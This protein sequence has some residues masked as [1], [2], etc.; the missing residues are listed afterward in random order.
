MGPG[1]TSGTRFALLPFL[2][3]LLP[4][5]VPALLGSL[6][7]APAPAVAPVRS[8]AP[9]S[10]VLRDPYQPPDDEWMGGGGA[11]NGYESPAEAGYPGQYGFSTPGAVMPGGA[12]VPAYAAVPD[13]YFPAAAPSEAAMVPYAPVVNLL[14]RV[15]RLGNTALRRLVQRFPALGRL[16][17]VIRELARRGI[18]IPIP[19]PTSRP[20]LPSARDITGRR[21]R[22]RCVRVCAPR[23]RARGCA[24]R[25]GHKAG[26][27]CVVCY[28]PS[29]SRGRRRR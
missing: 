24:P 17:E 2:G 14:S 6:F 26:C 11:V 3:S 8:Y 22:R 9:I 15:L 21:R 16:P 27:R 4:A 5:V 25:R 23:R 12:P 7:P 29:R 18:P 13:P 19:I 1:P 10:D 28:A 20:G